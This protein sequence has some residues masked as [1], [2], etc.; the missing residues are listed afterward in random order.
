MDL[1]G[2]K[3]GLPKE[4]YEEHVIDETKKIKAKKITRFLIDSLDQ[5][6]GEVLNPFIDKL[7][8]EFPKD[9]GY[10]WRQR[11]RFDNLVTMNTLCNA[12]RRPAVTINDRKV[13]IVTLEDLSFANRI[14]QD[15]DVLPP[16]KKIW[17][18]EVFLN[19]WKEN[20]EEID[21]LKIS[22][23]VITGSRIK[24]YAEEKSKG[25]ASVKAT[26]ETFLEPL[27]DH[28]YIDKTRDPR[29]H[30]RDVYWP[31]N[32]NEKD[33]TSL[34]AITSFDASCVKS[35]LEKYLKRRFEYT[36]KNEKITEDELIQ[37]VIGT[38]QN[39]PENHNDETTFDDVSA[40]D[41]KTIPNGDLRSFTN[42]ESKH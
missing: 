29:I 18:R 8:E 12:D 14:T 39:E 2:K 13:P 41:D 31:V 5:S 36:F 7:S 40:T 19:A 33:K 10:R 11:Q 6:K 30:T 21:E 20:S 28:G 37:N 26:R 27:Y 23:P 3:I 16:H 24:D 25:K 32:E 4:I 34:I 1:I 38:P 42:E 35:C 22:K 9:A 15:A 17:Y